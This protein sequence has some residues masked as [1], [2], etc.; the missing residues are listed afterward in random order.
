MNRGGAQWPHPAPLVWVLNV[1]DG[2]AELYDECRLAVLGDGVLRALFPI[3]EPG[4][5]SSR[6]R[7]DRSVTGAPYC[8]RHI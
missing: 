5:I 6:P 7:T 2:L 8:D 4:E 1:G 3:M